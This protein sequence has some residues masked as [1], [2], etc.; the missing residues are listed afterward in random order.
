MADKNFKEML[1]DISTFVFD[2]DGVF[3]NNQVLLMPDGQAVRSINTRDGYAVQLAV[4]EGFR[5]CVLSGG[6]GYGMSKRFERLG[7]KDVFMDVPEK[8]LVLQK[9]ME[10]HSLQREEVMYMGDDIPDLKVM[11]LAGVATC[12]KDAAPEI[13]AISHHVSP[14]N[15]GMGCARDVL[16][17]VMKVQGKWMS[18]GAFSW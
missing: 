1:A 3:T 2:V 6:D 15:G 14:F 16:E 12:P 10:D 5:I 13:R 7:V 4:K 17:Q 8:L 11:Q 9:Y 18:N